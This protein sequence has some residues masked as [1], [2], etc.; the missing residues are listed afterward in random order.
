[1]EHA[2]F[3]AQQFWAGIVGWAI[4]Y[5]S[6]RIINEKS[7]S[8]LPNILIALPYGMIAGKILLLTARNPSWKYFQDWNSVIGLMHI[9]S[10]PLFVGTVLYA[11]Y[12]LFLRWQKCRAQ[13]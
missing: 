4:L 6:L 7:V 13:I 8:F 10:L 12:C 2:P 3:D 1:M 9:I 5:G 11:V